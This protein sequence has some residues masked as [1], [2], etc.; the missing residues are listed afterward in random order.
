MRALVISDIHGNIEVLRAL[1]RQWGARL[2]EFDR[3]VCLGDL[4][5]YGPDPGEVIDWVRSRATDVIRGNHD[6]AMATGEPCGSAPAYLEASIL[7]R[8]RL[9]STLTKDELAY[10][11]QLPM[12][13]TLTAGGVN[14]HLVHATPADPLHA[15]VSPDSTDEHWVSALA[16]LTGQIVLVGHTHLAFVRSV[17]GGL[18]INPGSIGMP[19]DGHPFGSYVIIQDHAAHFCR[20]VYDPEPMITRLRSLDLPAHVV[21]QLTRTFRTGT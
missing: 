21:D 11:D 5:D 1:E 16:G 18:V 15:Y 7:T 14:W 10:L 3:V 19:R 17:A 4:V 13:Q 2:D 6:H 8:E 12:R 20:T 9:Q